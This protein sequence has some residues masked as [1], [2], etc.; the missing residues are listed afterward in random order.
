VS[1]VAG[2]VLAVLYTVS[3]LGLCAATLTVAAA[4]LAGGICQTTSA[5][6]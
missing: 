2:F 4:A 6:C 5:E 1:I 3:P